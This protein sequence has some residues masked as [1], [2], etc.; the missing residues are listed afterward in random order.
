MTSCW[1]VDR[2][3]SLEDNDKR[4][5]TQS[6]AKGKAGA[7]KVSK[8]KGAMKRLKQA[9]VRIQRKEKKVGEKI[10]SDV[11]KLRTRDELKM[12]QD[13]ESRDIQERDA[14]DEPDDL[15]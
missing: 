5:S 2:R 12:F 15:E 11:K 1:K 13:I 3:R 14:W 6:S 8:E 9:D 10:K 7:V 4:R